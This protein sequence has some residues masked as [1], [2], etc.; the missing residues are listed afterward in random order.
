[1]L[2][3]VDLKAISSLLD[4]KFKKELK[5][6]KE[7]VIQI[8][9]DQKMIVKFFDNEYLSL[10]KRVERIEGFLKLPPVN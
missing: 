3:K 6:I 5:P 1:M 2:T 9:R 10:R 7:D 8:R 4:E